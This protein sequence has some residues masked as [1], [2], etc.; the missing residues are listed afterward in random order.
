M[1]RKKTGEYTKTKYKQLH[2]IRWKITEQKSSQYSNVV[3]IGTIK[4]PFRLIKFYE[5]KI[6]NNWKII[7]FVRQDCIN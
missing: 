2:G 7:S 3:N 6:N 4:K 1:N 5:K